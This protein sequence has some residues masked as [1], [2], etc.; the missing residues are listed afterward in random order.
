[1]TTQDPYADYEAALA[2]YSEALAR[3]EAGDQ[4]PELET[5]VDRLYEESLSAYARLSAGQPPAPA[6]ETAIPDFAPAASEQPAADVPAVEDV[7]AEVPS[8][9]P[10]WAP[11][12]A[13]SPT[14]DLS[15]VPPLPAAP[16]QAQPTPDA[17]GGPVLGRRQK[18]VRF[19]PPAENAPSEQPL[20]RDVLSALRTEKRSEIG[21]ERKI[22]GNLP[23]WDLVPPSEVLPVARR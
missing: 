2:R 8:A 20:R 9:A 17:S 13:A 6:A 10:A 7:R 18:L 16:A 19:S 22:A 21:R 1:M 5:T 14:F 15:D 12:P 23:E 11:S 4:Q 3:L